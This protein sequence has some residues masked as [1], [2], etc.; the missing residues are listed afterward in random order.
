MSLGTV[1]V[2]SL[3]CSCAIPNFM[4]LF[5]FKP[6]GVFSSHIPFLFVLFDMEEQGV[7]V[8]VSRLTQMGADMEQD[9]DELRLVLP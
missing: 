4:L 7:S 3:K 2:A 6:L 8:D 5:S 1:C 9:L